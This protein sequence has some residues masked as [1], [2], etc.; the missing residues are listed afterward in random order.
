[1][2]KMFAEHHIHA[3]NNEGDTLLLVVARTEEDYMCEGDTLEL[4]KLLVELGLDPTRENSGRAS[5]LDI[6]AAYGNEN[7]LALYARNE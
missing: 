4:F 1:M 7:I 3:V 5:A 6:A 2:P